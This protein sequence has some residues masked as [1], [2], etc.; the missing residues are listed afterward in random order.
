[1][2]RR[3]NSRVARRCFGERISG[4]GRSG[5]TTEVE[6]AAVEDAIREGAAARAGATA[7]GAWVFECAGVLLEGRLWTVLGEESPGSS[8][9]ESSRWRR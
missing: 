8:S 5:V 2:R 6:G 9:S 1:M 7:D 4:I 3:R